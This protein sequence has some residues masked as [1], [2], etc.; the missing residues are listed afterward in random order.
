MIRRC[1]TLLSACTVAACGSSTSA[2]TPPE[3]PSLRLRI[4][5]NQT[6]GA[7]TDAV[8]A[9]LLQC[10]TAQG[11]RPDRAVLQIADQALAERVMQV[12]DVHVATASHGVESGSKLEGSAYIR[13]LAAEPEAPTDENGNGSNL[14]E[15]LAAEYKK[16]AVRA[17]GVVTPGL[18]PILFGWRDAFADFAT[19]GSA[20]D[21]RRSTGQ[22]AAGDVSMAQVAQGMLARLILG[23]YYVQR[24]RGSRP[25]ETPEK[26]VWGL[27]LLQQVV[28]MEE[29]LFSQLFMN[30]DA[31]G[32]FQFPQDY[33]PT[34]DPIRWLPSRIRAQADARGF[35]SSYGLIDR[36]SELEVVAAMMRV[37]AELSFYK[38]DDNPNPNLRDIFRGNPFGKKPG[39]GGPGSGGQLDR[40][41]EAEIV[42]WEDGVSEIMQNNCVFCHSESF[43][44]SGFKADSY[45][46]VLLGGDRSK[47]NSSNP[48][49]TRGN[50]DNSLFYRILLETPPAPFPRMPQFGELKPPQIDLIRT[51]ILDGARSAPPGP[52][53]LGVDLA[54]VMFKNLIALHF[55]EKTAGLYERHYGGDGGEVAFVDVAAT[56]SVLQAL[57]AMQHLAPELTTQKTGFSL[58]LPTATA[59]IAEF[60]L[61]QLTD[62]DRRGLRRIRFRRGCRQRASRSI[63]PRAPDCRP[64]GGRPC[65]GVNRARRARQ[66]ARGA[67]PR[68][69]LR[70][71]RW[72][73]SQ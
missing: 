13:R 19:P 18:R 72:P 9:A 51:W 24:N 67:A 2:P 15:T 65:A 36:S 71:G 35:T 3:E 43:P 11:Y 42:T 29:T 63:R 57:A 59:R 4:S 6:G 47:P 38:S 44:T 66:A 73:L 56:G 7:A 22:L 8:A 50:P 69:V 58:D 68:Y 5:G 31:L 25:G 12:A 23:T 33:K 45:D 21:F 30:G 34:E 14:D 60:A 40:G 46:N 26:G 39:S 55:D 28:A 1:V 10:T 32:A 49:I 53:D 61:E 52:P 17:G 27:S 62:P 70:A 64:L 54:T 20:D 48:I 41:S 16:L 37:G